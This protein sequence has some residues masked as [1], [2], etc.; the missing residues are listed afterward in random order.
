MGATHSSQ[1]A[2][3]DAGHSSTCCC[4]THEMSELPTPL[5]VANRPSREM[6]YTGITRSSSKQASCSHPYLSPELQLPQ[7]SP[8]QH[9][10]ENLE[11]SDAYANRLQKGDVFANLSKLDASFQKLY[12]MKCLSK[13]S[14]MLPLS[15]QS[16]LSTVDNR[17]R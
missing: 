11:K 3:P 16:K 14:P 8:E 1:H 17:R 12:Q 6:R 2:A 5:I 15:L 4:P 10:S 13:R 7:R 9:R